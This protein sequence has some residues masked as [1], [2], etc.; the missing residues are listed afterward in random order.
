MAEMLNPNIGDKYHAMETQ[1]DDGEAEY[2]AA[3]W[4]FQIV[5]TA[6]DMVALC[7]NKEDRDHILKLL[8]ANP[9]PE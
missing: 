2:D 8:N 6:G 5:D 1:H 4:N 7:G 3:D 9:I